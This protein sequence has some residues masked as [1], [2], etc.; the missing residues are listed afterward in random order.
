MSD[1]SLRV[2]TDLADTWHRDPAA[3]LDCAD[4][5][6]VEKSLLEQLAA[7]E[8]RRNAGGD[9]YAGIPVADFTTPV[10]PKSRAA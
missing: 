3:A 4:A 2:Q 10:H 1:L 6:N 7:I 8:A 5:F 9:P